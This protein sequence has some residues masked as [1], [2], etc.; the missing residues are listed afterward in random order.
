MFNKNTILTCLFFLI[1]LL[2]SESQSFPNSVIQIEIKGNRI[3]KDYIIHREIHHAINVPYDSVLAS[4]DKNRIDNLGIF[5]DVKF[6]LQGNG[7]GTSTLFYE[8]I[9]TW[10]IFPVPIVRYEEETG[11]A[12]G[13]VGFIK[14]FRGR[15]QDF[16]V[17]AAGG[18]TSFKGVVF[19]DPW[20]AGDHISLEAEVIDIFFEH[21]Y[22]QYDFTVTNLELKL[23]KFFGYKRKLWVTFQY[24]DRNVTYLN[25]TPELNHLH[26][27]TEFEFHFDTR[28]LYVNPSRGM[29]YRFSMNPEYGLNSGSPNNVAIFNQVSFFKTLIQGRRNWVSGVS[30][31]VQKWFGPGIDYQ[32]QLIGGQKSV[33]GWSIPDT[34][35]IVNEEFRTGLNIYNASVELRQ[36][37]IPKY[38]TRFGTEFGM[39]LVEFFD[40]GIVDDNFLN[41]WDKSPI[42]G[43]G[44][45]VRIFIP[46]AKLLR[47]DY[48]WGY[49]ERKF[50]SPELHFD[51]GH[52]F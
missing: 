9:E 32:E 40:M 13:G 42:F 26:F 5:S 21:P 35:S 46:G 39:I 52:K 20:I 51:I 27:V 23:G 29:I 24:K 34:V 45:G 31:S 15:N 16:S 44:F 14:N 3:T 50:Q 38:I 25:Q 43:V 49:Y 8:V 41:L 33:R 19:K 17:F 30:F 7:D 1:H 11:W 22:R 12:F 6:Y 18:G 36:T 10:R 28:D 4:E 2:F 48:A 47:L 37:V